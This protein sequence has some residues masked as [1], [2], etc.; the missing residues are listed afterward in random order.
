MISRISW[1]VGV[2]VD[3]GNGNATDY[4]GGHGDLGNGVTKAEVGT[5]AAA[6]YANIG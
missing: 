6:S 3:Q 2:L 4:I 1:L 5:G